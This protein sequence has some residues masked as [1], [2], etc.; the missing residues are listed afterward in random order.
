[1]SLLHI[2]IIPFSYSQGHLYLPWSRV[3]VKFKC[4][5]WGIY[6][7]HLKP[8]QIA[9][10]YRCHHIQAAVD[11]SHHV[12]YSQSEQQ[13]TDVTTRK[14]KLCSERY[15]IMLLLLFCSMH[16]ICKNQSHIAHN[17]TQ[18]WNAFDWIQLDIHFQ[19]DGET[20][21]KNKN[22]SIMTHYLYILS[23]LT[24]YFIYYFLHNLK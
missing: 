1:M 8:S 23:T 17:T 14:P 15:N 22:Q 7:K 19:Y 12:T 21:S 2:S 3:A 6:R 24:Y 10:H 11:S 9:A 4:E 5:A 16:T 20:G 18:Q 13:Y